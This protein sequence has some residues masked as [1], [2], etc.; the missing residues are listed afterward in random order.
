MLSILTPVGMVDVRNWRFS[1]NASSLGRVSATSSSVEWTPNFAVRLCRW[2]RTVL[3]ES[4]S[5][6]RDLF[7][8]GALEQVE[9]DIPLA[10]RESRQQLIAAAGG[11]PD[12][13]SAGAAPRL[14]LRVAASFR[15]APR[16]G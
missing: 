6:Y 15:R 10:W 9:Q 7:T 2:E 13:R 12:H 3:I 11:P 1:G 4:C 16:S 14:V 5:R 8:P